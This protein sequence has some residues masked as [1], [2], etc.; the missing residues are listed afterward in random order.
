MDTFKNISLWQ[1]CISALPDE[2]FF[3]I[4]R[5]YLGEVKTPYNKQRLIEQLASFIRNETN[6]NTMLLLMDEFDI[7]VLTAIRFI[8]NATTN[9]LIDFFA[10]DYSVADIYSEIS[11][12]TLR[13]FIY[14]EADKYS[15]KVFLRLNPLMWDKL[16]SY[17]QLGNILSEA[18]IMSYSMDDIFCIN[19]NFLCD[20]ISFI[21]TYGCACKN[22]GSIKKNDMNRLMNVFPGKIQCIQL[23]LSAF[24]NLNL[25]K[26][27]E[28]A[29]EIDYKRFELFAGLKN[30]Q[31]YALLC[32]ASCSRFGRDGLKKEAQLFID[33]LS[34]IPEGGYTRSTLVKLAFLIGTHGSDG[35]QSSVKSR[36]SRMLE[37]AKM[38]KGLFD[39]EQAGSIIDRMIDFAIVFGLLQKK[40]LDEKGKE[41]YIPGSAFLE[42][43]Q[44]YY[45]NEVSEG[46]K[47][48]NIDST[49][50]VTIMPGLNLKEL[51]PLACVL[52]IKNSSVVSEY[53]INRQVISLAFDEGATPDSIFTLLESRTAYGLPQNLKITISEWYNSYTSAML[54]H[55]YI[56]KVSDSNIT[57]AENNPNIKKYIK[58][59]LAEGIYL[60]N[61]PATADISPFI[62]ESGLDF[63]GRVNNPTNN[64]ERMQ[65]PLLRSGKVLS[66][67]SSSNEVKIRFSQAGE[68]LTELK[69]ALETME[70]RENQ[71]ET[72]LHK[73][74]QRL[75]LTKKQLEITSV[76]AEILEADGMDFG[77]KIHLFEAAI[78]EGDMVE[79]TM[80]K[81]NST[82]EYFTIIGKALGISKQYADAII[83]FQ[84]HPT[85]DIENLVASRIT[86]VRRLRY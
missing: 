1:E 44:H 84:I 7:K 14:G 13:L 10:E 21:H 55:G 17:L 35:A 51:L 79:I 65:F 52:A 4:I 59:K 60:L 50:T 40:G 37:S 49:F 71:K 81:M 47:V 28:K 46:P 70:L 53:E 43:N 39:A 2:K 16:E 74:H 33:C 24:I 12:L 38:E 85:M 30:S 36:F 11:N 66:L 82:D 80:P 45:E 72:L 64:E 18:S 73:I 26:E 6:L 8:P 22:D 67:S 9:L 15:N 27:G 42:E 58:E 61:V 86:H 41:I 69:Q 77:G 76:R 29:Y 78:K 20:F 75:I 57:F 5:L 25:V 63:M 68:L 83:R 34:S 56:L 54:Y 31:Q 32:A 23:L 62:T 48:I 19:P 3:E